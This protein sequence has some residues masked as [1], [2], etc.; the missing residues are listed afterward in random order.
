MQNFCISAV[1][2]PGRMKLLSYEFPEVST[3]FCL[4]SQYIAISPNRISI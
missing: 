2:E 4:Q 1:T 3:L